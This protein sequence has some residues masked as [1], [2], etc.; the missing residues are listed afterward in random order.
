M[1]EGGGG[2]DGGCKVEVRVVA[3]RAV[4]RMGDG[5]VGGGDGG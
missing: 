4:E 3:A 1:R 2:R 5:E